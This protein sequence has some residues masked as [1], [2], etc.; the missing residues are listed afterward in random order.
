M[1][2]QFKAIFDAHLF[3]AG[4]GFLLFLLLAFGFDYATDEK[5]LVNSFIFDIFYSFL[6]GALL[7][8]VPI[9]TVTNKEVLKKRTAIVELMGFVLIG[10]LL[11]LTVFVG[12]F[13]RR[14]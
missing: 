6:V 2:E 9:K 12:I 8:F 7:Y 10:F 4:L 11:F 1:K 3:N 5:I 13:S 14:I